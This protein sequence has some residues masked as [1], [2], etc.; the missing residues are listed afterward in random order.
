MDRNDLQRIKVRRLAQWMKGEKAGP[1]KIDLEPTSACNLKCKFCWTRSDERLSNCQYDKLLSDER[2]MEIIDEAARL[3]VVEWQIAGGWEP[4]A[5]P[6]LF[7]DIAKMIKSHEM[8]GCVTTNGTLFDDDMARALVE[9]GWDEILFSLEGADAATHDPLTEVPGSFDRSTNAM[10]MLKKWKEKLGKSKPDYSFHAVLTRKNYKQLADMIR[11]GKQVGC[12]GVN[13]EPLSVW[14]DAAKDLKLDDAQT[15]EVKA[16]AKEALDVSRKLG[17][18]T[19]AE[20]L[21]R[22]ELVKKENMDRILIE[23]AGDVR[24]G[25]KVNGGILGAPCFDPWLGI[26]VRVNGRVAPCRICNF[27]SDCPTVIDAGLSDVWFGRYFDD[28]RQKMISGVMP[29]F[30]GSCA[31]GNVA[32]TTRM[33]YELAKLQNDSATTKIRNI[34]FGKQV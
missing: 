2:I 15:Q 16:Y 8:Y 13:F 26:E 17:V 21:L 24:F 34:L 6:R 14:S 23:N 9:I 18:H 31:A 27:D 25:G 12:T 5:R 11:L 7:V 29:A 19:N 20:N 30:C 28:A 32:D 10:R 4:T 1:V 3:G 22:A 33:K